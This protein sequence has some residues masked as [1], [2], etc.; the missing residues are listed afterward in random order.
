MDPSN[1]GLKAFGVDAPVSR[2]YARC[3]EARYTFLM[4]SSLL[5]ARRLRTLMTAVVVGASVLT[6]CDRRGDS[7]EPTGVPVTEETR[8][9]LSTRLQVESDGNWYEALVTEINPDGT[10]RVHFTAWDSRYD[11]DVPRD[12]MRLAPVPETPGPEAPA[13]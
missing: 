4:Q 11:E 2:R 9:G 10:Y 13:E 5:K 1:D 6:A 3:L 12:R 7:I 8:I